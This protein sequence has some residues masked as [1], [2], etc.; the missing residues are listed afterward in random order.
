M[1]VRNL[2]GYNYDPY[3]VKSGDTFDSVASN[4]NITPA[5]IQGANNGMLVPPP[6]G[7]YI[8]LPRGTIQGKQNAGYYQTGENEKLTIQQGGNTVRLGPNSSLAPTGPMN[9]IQK[10]INS[11]KPQGGNFSG[12]RGSV[13]PNQ[14]VNGLAMPTAFGGGVGAQ[15][16]A[17][18]VQP[19]NGILNL[20]GGTPAQLKNTNN[21]Y[22]PPSNAAPI[23]KRNVPLNIDPNAG[24]DV[25][26][27]GQ[28]Y[29]HQV[30]QE[31]AGLQNSMN[32]FQQS[33]N[34]TGQPNFNLLPKTIS[35]AATE[36]VA[37]QYGMTASEWAN[38]SGY[39]YTNGQYVQTGVPQTGQ[40]GEQPLQAGQIVDNKFQAVWSQREG[41]YILRDI[42]RRRDRAK[43]IVA[44]ATNAGTTPGDVL[45]LRLGGG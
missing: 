3:Q 24:Q 11:L 9:F 26:G 4:Y 45:S 13:Q 28:P 35:P 32:Q 10:I 44:E 37:Q 6:K 34:L 14:K 38:Q 15:G 27:R 39:K 5:D 17:G 43:P 16:S 12:V 41:K 19:M 29:F 25:T 36:K 2:R 20:N 18:G 7:S 42:N 8:N 1:A 40:A 22:T 33:F 23:P 31:A 21:A 30:A